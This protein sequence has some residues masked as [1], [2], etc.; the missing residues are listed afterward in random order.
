MRNRLRNS[1]PGQDGGHV[2]TQTDTEK[3]AVE[4]ELVNAVRRAFG[5]DASGQTG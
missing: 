5:R 3:L 4:E 1:P 2:Q